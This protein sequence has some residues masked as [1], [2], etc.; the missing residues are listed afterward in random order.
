MFFVF[1][2]RAAVILLTLTVIRP[3]NSFGFNVELNLTYRLEDSVLIQG[4][5]RYQVFEFEARA[6]GSYDDIKSYDINHGLT[7]SVVYVL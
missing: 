1:W 5:C 2:F 4:G 3:W 7:L 6:P